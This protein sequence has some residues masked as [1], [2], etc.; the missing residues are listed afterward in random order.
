VDIG[1]IAEL[2]YINYDDRQGLTIGALTPIRSLERSPELQSRFPVISQAASLLGSVAI[3]NVGTIGG[4]LCNAAPS[5]ETAPTLIGL[6][7]RARI[8]GPDGERVISLEAFFKGPGVTVLK[9]DELL[10]EIQVPKPELN[11]RVIYYKH[12]PR[13]TIDL[14]IVGVAVI[15]TFKTSSEICKDIKIVLGAVAPTPIRAR[16]AEDILRDKKID[17]LLTNRSA[18]TAANE[19]NC[20]SDVRASAEYRKEMVE[21]LTRRAIKKVVTG[22]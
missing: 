18:V 10:V 22:I 8:I 4:N 9:K 5:A 15:A 6:S 17:D 20:I 7:A 13:G 1:G 16:K 19:S 2:N 11:T 3:R 14:A 21:V 12:S